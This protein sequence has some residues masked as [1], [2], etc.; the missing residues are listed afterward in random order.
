MDLHRNDPIHNKSVTHNNR[1]RHVHPNIDQ[2]VSDYGSTWNHGQ[3]F[4][5]PI[6]C[7]YGKLPYQSNSKEGDKSCTELL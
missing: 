2:C 1:T 7:E 3:E 5:Q 6:E 4:H